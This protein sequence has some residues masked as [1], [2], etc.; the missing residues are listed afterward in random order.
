M[1]FLLRDKPLSDEEIQ[2]RVAAAQQLARL[3]IQMYDRFN[4]ETQREQLNNLVP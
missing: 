2:R 1:A 3:M 4:S